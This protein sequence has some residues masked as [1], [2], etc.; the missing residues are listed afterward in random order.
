MSDMLPH[1]ARTV[2]VPIAKP[3][4]APHMLEL[5]VWLLDPEVGKLYALTVSVGSDESMSETLE[6]LQPIVDDF[7]ARG[8]QVELLAEVSGSISRGIL[9]AT[10]EY[11]ADTLIMGVERHGQEQ[12]SL[13]SVVENVIQAATC[14]VLV[15]RYGATPEYD[16]VLVPIDGSRHGTVALNTAVMLAKSRELPLTPLYI[17]RDYIYRP[18]HEKQVRQSLGE[19]DRKLV[20]KEII[21][22]KDP[23]HY[24]LGELTEDDLLVLGFSQKADF[25]DQLEDDVAERLLNSAPGPVL[26]ASRLLYRDDMVGRF[27]RRLQR[28]NPALTEIERSEIVWQAQ[29][30]AMANIDYLI[31]IVLSAGLASLGLLLNSVAVIIGAMLVAPLMSPLAALSTGLI[32]A[33]PSLIERSGLT[34]IQGVLLALLVSILSGVLIPVPEPTSEMLARGTPSLLDAAVAL[35]S[36]WVAAYATSRKNIPAALAGVAIAA[37][38]MPP[39]CTIGLGIALREPLLAG[40]ATLLFTTN[41]VFIVVAQY[42]VF[43]WVG[44]RPGNNLTQEANRGLQVWWTVIAGLLV[45]VMALLVALGDRATS[46]N[47]ARDYLANQFPSADLMDFALTSGS[48]ALIEATFFSDSQFDPEQVAQAEAGLQQFFPD[49]VQLEVA[50]LLAVRPPDPRL[51]NVLEQL[52]ESFPQSDISDVRIT[53]HEDSIEIDALAQTEQPITLA[54]V[55]QAQAD[56]AAR[57]GQPVIL[58]L[59]IQQIITADDLP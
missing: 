51:S 55:E 46:Q 38:L 16:R 37:A 42:M 31:L 35:V 28:F 25:E 19:I 12:V 18:D 22:S 10:R 21:S 3:E 36:G 27:Q 56:L 9:D 50:V 44:M 53:D 59:A 6:T 58:H 43:L 32:A 7:I 14:D 40:G 54:D 29:R 34:L 20:H 13:G 41:I 33:R 8:H 23:G 26:V 4:T 17:Q 11:Q 1:Y 2:I 5:A 30:N 24:I 49:P 57:L 48:P 45:I 52:H 15:Y 47:R 39:V